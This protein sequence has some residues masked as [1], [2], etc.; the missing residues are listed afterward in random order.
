MQKTDLKCERLKH[1]ANGLIGLRTTQ[2][3]CEWSDRRC[4]QRK[5]VAIGLN[6]IAM[7]AFAVRIARKSL[8]PIKNEARNAKKSLRTM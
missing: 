7:N 1:A 2:T 5:C 4:E 6:R 8:P 3:R